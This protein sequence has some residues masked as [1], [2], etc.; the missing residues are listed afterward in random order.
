MAIAVIMPKLE[1]SQEAATV[2]AWLKEEGEHVEKGEPL[3]TVETDK[4]TMDI[5]SPGA[6][7]L[8]GVRAE[9]D[10]VVPVTETIAFLL[11]PGEEL[12]DAGRAVPREGG[13][14]G[15]G[16]AQHPHP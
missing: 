14:L 5:E 8:A 7:I 6:G 3:L 13:D 10:Q 15:P 11:Q 9:I 12:P 4:V 16:R 2:L 1:M